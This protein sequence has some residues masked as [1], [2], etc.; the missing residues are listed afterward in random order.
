[1]TRTTSNEPSST[2]PED[3]VMLNDLT[4]A[5]PY[6]QLLRDNGLGSL[7]DLCTE[8]LGES[9]H[10]PGLDTWRE[11]LRLTLT[12][13]SGPQTVYLKRFFHPPA[14]VQR[15]VRGSDTGAKSVA[16]LEWAWMHRLAADGIPTIQP[17]AFGEELRGGRE[18]RSAILSAKVPGDSLER[19][20]A[21]WGPQQRPTVRRVLG[22]TADLVARFHRCGYVHRDLYLSHIF[23]DDRAA[24]AGALHLIDLQRVMKPKWRAGR[25]R[26]KDLASLNYS[27]PAALVTTGDRVRWL[28]CYLELTS[29]PLRK[30]TGFA[31]GPVPG[32]TSN[33]DR[34]ACTPSRRTAKLDPRARHLIRR[35]VAKTRRIARHDRRRRAWLQAGGSG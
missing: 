30:E 3:P 35:I 20:A 19:L 12:H 7:D 2:S 31:P 9:L 18:I 15:S 26:V 8:S 27:T 25:W 17:I 22:T 21:T 13:G 4:I 34:G 29:S 6:A 16:G 11:R 5:A 14:R 1:M 10:K 23:F 28:K 24:E 33:E 32:I